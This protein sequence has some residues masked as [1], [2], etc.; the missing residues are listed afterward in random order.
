LFKKKSS[1]EVKTTPLSEEELREVVKPDTSVNLNQISASYAR[2]M[3]K[4]RD[5]NE[6]SIFTFSGTITYGEKDQN[7]GLY[8][9][10]DGMGGHQNGALASGSAARVFGKYVLENF[11]VPILD[12]DKNTPAQSLQ[13]IM[14]NA[15]KAAQFAVQKHAP[16]GGTTLTAVLAVGEQVTL[17]H[18]G[19]SRCYFIHLDGRCNILTQDHSLVHRLVELGQLDEEMAKVH[20]QR[21]VLYRAV[22]Q[23]DPFIPDIATHQIQRPGY[24]LLCSDGLWGV[25]SNDEIIRIVLE[26]R[27]PSVACETLIDAAN[28]AGGPDNISVILVLFS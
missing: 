13:E 15:V 2:S 25:V 17:A 12:P 10:A 19:D 9:V 14:E 18:V 8:V 26:K 27:I 11:L 4:Q 7:L 16:G 5:H 22:G 23:A 3:G 21:N 1:T 28:E 20:L 24:L 6:D